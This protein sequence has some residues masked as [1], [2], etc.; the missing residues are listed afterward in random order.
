MA[1]MKQI[2]TKMPPLI[3]GTAWKKDKTTKLVRKAVELGFRGID[4]ACQPK[5]YNEAGVGE[6]LKEL[7]KLG[8]DRK[9]L[10]IQT[11]YTPIG[12]H[13]HNVPYDKTASLTNQ[14]LQSFAKSQEN[15]G[16]DYVDSYVLH[17][18]LDKQSDLIEVWRAFETIYNKG[19][20]KQLGI[21]NCYDISVLKALYDKSSVKPSVVQ[22]RFHNKSHYDG[23]LREWCKEKGITYQSFWTL[24]A[25]PE[26]L[27]DPSTVSIAKSLKRT[28]AQVFF[29]FLS[30]HEGIVPL[31]G[32]TSEEHMKQDL[33]IVNF[34]LSSEQCAQIAKLL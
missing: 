34:S 16:T 25:N 6:A 29:R 18:P 22:N 7:K 33:D 10:F 21:S 15:L 30:Q 5:H 17:S 19:Q 2:V 13:D 31:T 11:K 23:Q 28:E 4:T 9:D 1:D 8:I 20:A 14:V 32:T 12:G 26:I 3:Y 24:T 27:R